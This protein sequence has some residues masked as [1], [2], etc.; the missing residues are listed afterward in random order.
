MLNLDIIT[1][2]TLIDDTTRDVDNRG[3]IISI[4]DSPVKNV[5]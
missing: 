1:K 4:V 2:S 3:S 5:S